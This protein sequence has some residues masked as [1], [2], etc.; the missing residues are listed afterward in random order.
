MIRSP[1]E[2]TIAIGRSAELDALIDRLDRTTSGSGSLVLVGGDA[3]IGKST[4]MRELKRE[5][6]AREI[7]V[8]EGRC[9]STESSVPYAPLMDALRFRISKGEGKAVAEML[10]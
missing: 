7:R 9:S 10:G 2:S 8:I 6:T 3:G 4:L 1:V 5:G